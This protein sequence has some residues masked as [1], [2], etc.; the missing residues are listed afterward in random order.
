[1]KMLSRVLFVA[2]IG[3][4]CGLPAA[5]P[6][7]VVAD[8]PSLSTTPLVFFTPATNTAGFYRIKWVP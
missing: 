2:L 3:M 8:I 6:W 7:Q 1:M 5:G 4:T